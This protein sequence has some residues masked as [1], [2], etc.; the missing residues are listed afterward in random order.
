MAWYNQLSEELKKTFYSNK[1][2]SL[3]ASTSKNLS[4]SSPMMSR[5][6]GNNT[7]YGDINSYSQSF[8]GDIDYLIAQRNNLIKQ[9]RHATFTPEV[10]QALIEIVNEAIV[11]EENDRVPI[12][13]NL[14]DIEIA[15]KIKDEI[16]DSF[17]KILKLLNFKLKGQSLFRQWYVDGVLNLEVVYNNKKLSEG[18]KKIIVLSPFDFY[19][20]T[21][22][23]SGETKFFYNAMLNQRQNNRNN[24]LSL[25]DLAKDVEL[26]FKPE[27]ITQI[28]SGLFSED[29]LFPISYVNKSLKIINQ[30]SLIEDS[31]IIYRITRAPE[32][33]VFKIDT[34]RL[35][36]S[37]SEQYVKRMMDKHRNKLTYNISTGE[38][39]NRKGSISVLEDFWIPVNADG[40]GTEIDTLSGTGADLSDIADLEYFYKKLYKSL[41][42]PINRLDSESQFTAVSTS[43]LDI[44]KEEVK[45]FK[46]VSSLRKN[47]NGMFYDLL[48]K[49]LLAKKVFSLQDWNNIKESIVVE[50]T[51]NNNF[52]QARRLSNLDDLMNIANT[53]LDLVGEGIMTKEWVQKEVLNFNDEDLKLFDKQREKE[54]EKAKAEKEKYGLEDDD[55]Y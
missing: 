53:A 26:E 4:T 42:V 32:K 18:I 55:D 44:E 6:E 46:F 17:S 12:K 34:G 20:C 48:K 52:A 54:L 47:F 24:Q 50:Y 13:L 7:M 43:S 2:A 35:S 16:L 5:E 19:K 33:R 31:I 23:E 30:L 21:D 45:L 8:G 29:R 11:F 37:K 49:D 3:T 51:N 15:D 39:E 22:I 9:W 40:K 14:D 36:K 28:D 38:I 25:M 27:Q 10:D 41:N 1:E